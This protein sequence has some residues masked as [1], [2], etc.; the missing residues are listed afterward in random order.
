MAEENRSSEEIGMEMERIMPLYNKLLSETRDN[1][2]EI[3]E[4]VPNN[5]YDL[6]PLR[7]LHA[8]L[9][10]LSSCNYRLMGLAF[11]YI[12]QAQEEK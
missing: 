3:R 1:V 11:A 5:N 7:A 9:Q 6:M 4:N 2:R 8:Q 12:D 10:D